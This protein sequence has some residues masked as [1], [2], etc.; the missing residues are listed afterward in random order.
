ME[1]QSW[2]IDARGRSSHVDN[3]S[4]VDRDFSRGQRLFQE[5][6]N[7]DLSG[8][9]F[10]RRRFDDVRFVGVKLHDTVFCRCS[11]LN[12]K[13]AEC[14]V[15]NLF[16]DRCLVEESDLK[17]CRGSGI[18]AANTLC[19]RQTRWPSRRPAWRD[20][21]AVLGPAQRFTGF[22]LSNK[23]LAGL[24]YHDSDFRFVTC[25]WTSLADASL[26]NCSFRRADLTQCDLKNACLAG[27]DLR[28][29]DLSR[30]DLTG[31]V[32]RGADL[33][34]VKARS[35]MFNDATKISEVD[36]AAM[37]E[38]GALRVG[39]GVGL[40]GADLRAAN[41]IYKDLCNSDLRDADLRGAYLQGADLS[42]ADLSG[43][44]L[45]GIHPSGLKLTGATITGVRA[46]KKTLEF[47][48]R[49]AETAPDE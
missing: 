46:S 45:R 34:G 9:R 44:D 18:L 39:P 31:A 24:D 4:F 14:S 23:F 10:F 36:L 27:A 33:R 41:L 20:G 3:I 47:I 49:L 43:A 38:A 25:R 32:L 1:L 42:G 30:A 8:A 48:K 11:L 28:G 15:S 29:A 17:G 13:F 16:F 12:V 19:D 26:A 6:H 2:V 37:T 22:D 35:T 7:V 21:V 40:R 5:F